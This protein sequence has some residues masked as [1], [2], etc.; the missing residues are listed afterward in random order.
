[1]LLLKRSEITPSKSS[2]PPKSGAGKVNVWELIRKSL[3]MAPDIVV[4][5][6][7]T[8][9]PTDRWLWLRAVYDGP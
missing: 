2:C 1:M 7:E 4:E 6:K 3:N 9:L 8:E 5:N